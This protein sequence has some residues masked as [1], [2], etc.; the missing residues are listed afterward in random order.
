MPALTGA[1]YQV[2]RCD[3]S[4]YGDSP[5][6][7]GPFD[8]VQ[9]VADL[10]DSLGIERLAVVGASGGGRVA[11]EFAARWPARVS[12]LAL[13]C[14]AMRGH[15]PSVELRKFGAQEDALLE[16]GDVAGATELNVNLWLGPEADEATRS[17]VRMMQRHAFEVQLAVDA[18]AA[19]SEVAQAQAEAESAQ[20]QAQA[21]AKAPAPAPA[22][23][24][25]AQ[26][27]E[28][29]A[30]QAQAAHAQ[31]VHEQAAHAQAATTAEPAE[32]AELAPAQSATDRQLAANA[33][34]ATSQPTAEAEADAQQGATEDGGV[35]LSSIVAPAL[36]VSGA[37]DLPDFEE[38]AVHLA[39]VLPH[40]RHLHLD[41]AGHLPS[42]ER[43]D[44]T[45]ALLVSF[46]AN[47]S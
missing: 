10:L 26:A 34:L 36:V 33:E 7:D 24:A 1:G 6:P 38:I 22:Q 4:G 41:W 13:L 45:N 5:V 28:A 31:A 20:A 27:A 16:A 9:D 35:D 8:N 44:L 39:G 18:T 21:Q 23:G 2:V 17:K 29:E 3:L 46:L 25:Q 19:Q 37:H 11:L 40:A 30:A 32:K 42:L 12:A 47:P 43:P 15:E 14:S